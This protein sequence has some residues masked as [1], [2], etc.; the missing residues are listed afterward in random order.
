MKDINDKK[1]E[2]KEMINYITNTKQL[3]QFRL[4]TNLG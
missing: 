1:G 4:F 3:F 2:K